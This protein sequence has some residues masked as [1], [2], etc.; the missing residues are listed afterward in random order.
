MLAKVFSEQDM[1]VLPVVNHEKR[2]IGM[3]TSDDVIDVIQ[4][5]V[6]EDLYKIA[7]ISNKVIE[8][9][10]IKTPWYKI[11]QSRI[12]WLSLLLI[13]S[14][15]TQGI[16]HW[17]LHVTYISH[18][19]ADTASF[20]SLL[21]VAFAAIIPVLNN[22]VKNIGL[23]SNI[24]ISRSIALDEIDKKDFAKVVWKELLAAIVLA[25]V[26]VV[27]NFARLSAYFAATKDLLGDNKLKYL[28]LIIGTSVALFISVILSSLFGSLLPI[29][30]IKAKKDPSSASVIL[31]N[32]VVDFITVLITFGIT[33]GILVSI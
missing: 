7:G 3:I 14:T 12:L 24:S 27:V 8:N 23:Q 22:S 1:S 31:L 19:S 15:I 28:A 11:V 13:F 30:L 33:Y 25:S 6:T 5:E 32:L 4:D 10:Y 9:D 21:T 16:I 29:L 20:A 26:L 18:K 2:L 17:A